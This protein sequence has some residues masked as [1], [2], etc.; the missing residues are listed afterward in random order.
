[1]TV[2]MERAD[3]VLD[4]VR[5][6]LSVRPEIDLPATDPSAW[7]A[8]YEAGADTLLAR[9]ADELRNAHP[10]LRIETDLLRGH[11]P[12]VLLEYADRMAVDLI[13]VGQHGHGVVDLFLFGSVAQAM[14]TT[15]TR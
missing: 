12:T 11:A 9:L 3:K 15:N 13:A 5:A 8:I 7:S 4:R 2:E 1:M 10:G 6:D 14:S